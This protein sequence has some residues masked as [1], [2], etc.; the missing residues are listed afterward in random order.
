MFAE[1]VRFSTDDEISLRETV[2][3]IECWIARSMNCLFSVWTGDWFESHTLKSREIKN[4]RTKSDSS[5]QAENATAI[6]EQYLRNSAKYPCNFGKSG[7]GKIYQWHK[8]GESDCL[9]K[10]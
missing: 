6:G 8:I 10:T 4:Y 1:R 7:T 5:T 2:S 9:L 3:K